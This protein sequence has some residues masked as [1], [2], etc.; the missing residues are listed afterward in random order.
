[1][2]LIPG[3]AHAADPA[4]APGKGHGLAAPDQDLSEAI[5]S[6]TFTSPA[7]RSTKSAAPAAGASKAAGA[8]QTVADPTYK[9]GLTAKATSAHGIELSAAL[10]AAADQSL[11]VSVNWG[12]QGAEDYYYTTGPGLEKRQHIYREVGTYLITVTL[13]DGNGNSVTNTLS[14]T[15]VGSEFTPYTP[16]RLLDTRDGTGLPK[17]AKVDPYKSTRVKVGGFETI[18]AGVTAVALNVTVTN[19]NS[20]GHVTA[21]AEDTERPSTSNLNYEPGQTVPNLVIVPVGAN[22]YVELYNGGWESVDLIADVTGYF[23]QS[24][25]SGYTAIDPARHVDTRTGLGARKGQVAGFGT[26]STPIVGAGSVPSGATAVA[27]NVTV[28]N[29]KDAGH[30][31]V[32]PTGKKAPTASNLNFS[33]GQTVANAVIVPIGADGKISIRNGSWK[34]TDVIV[35]VVGY[36]SPTSQ[37]AYVPFDPF[38]RIDTRD[39]KSWKYGPLQGRWYIYMKLSTTLPGVKAYVLNTT[40]TNPKG[41]GFLGVAPD[42]NSKEAYDGGWASAPGSPTSSTLNFT[43]GKTVP[44][45][46]QA[47]TGYNGIVDLFNESDANID[48]VVDMFGVY[49]DF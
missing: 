10:E 14:V 20:G 8:P 39:P 27:L 5:A 4:P 48:V 24:A 31:T 40:V 6:K 34:G 15:T 41:V 7:A 29:P 17:A 44:N 26:I 19:T 30:L 23:T 13:A 32:F 47:S 45:L 11:H 38:R 1:M 28:T 22:G 25:A 12:D 43:P 2:S 21:F 37:A 49:D 16:T 9:V 3:L 18:P 35:D 42:P 46:V 36:Y 33:G